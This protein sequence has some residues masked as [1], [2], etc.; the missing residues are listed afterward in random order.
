MQPANELH[1]SIF[2]ITLPVVTFE[3]GNGSLLTKKAIT[4]QVSDASPS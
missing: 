2:Q 1:G 3:F 4:R